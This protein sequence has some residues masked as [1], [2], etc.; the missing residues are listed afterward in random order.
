MG[1]QRTRIGWRSVLLAVGVLVAGAGS[2][3]VAQHGQSVNGR[4]G[5]GPRPANLPA[6][7]GPKGPQ[8]APPP[9]LAEATR[10]RAAAE[11]RGEHVPMPVWDPATGDMAQ[12]RDGN[13]ILSDRLR[14]DPETGALARNRDGSLVVGDPMPHRPAPQAPAC[15]ATAKGC[16]Q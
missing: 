7:S 16:G 13:F 1:R 5:V 4:G 14:F 3:A 8:P 6:V 11:A 9:G 10:R 2:A 12:D 15:A